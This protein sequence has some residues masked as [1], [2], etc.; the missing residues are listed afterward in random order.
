VGVFYFL[1]LR[2]L[3]Q[4]LNLGMDLY[5]RDIEDDEKVEA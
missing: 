5:Y 1:V 3:A 4:L 2:G